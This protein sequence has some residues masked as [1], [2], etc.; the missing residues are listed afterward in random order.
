MPNTMYIA[1]FQYTG[2]E[3]APMLLRCCCLTV[4]V[5][6]DGLISYPEIWSLK[7][8]VRRIAACACLCEFSAR[9]AVLCWL[10]RFSLVSINRNAL[11]YLSVNVFITKVLT[12]DTIFYV[13]S[14]RRNRHFPWSS[15]PREGLPV[16]SAREYLHF[17][18]ILRPWVL[19]RRQESNPRP[20]A[21]QSTRSTAWA[22]TAAVIVDYSQHLYIFSCSEY[23]Q[24]H[25][26]SLGVKFLQNSYWY[27]ASRALRAPNHL[28]FASAGLD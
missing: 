10:L 20:P 17:S 21:L 4:T 3:F 26:Y 19:V 15:E 7:A 27:R 2:G 28:Y 5:G 11:F 23:F 8:S 6:M 25:I 18:V 1:L 12:G 14:W 22:N 16:C 13:S 9:L 24:Y